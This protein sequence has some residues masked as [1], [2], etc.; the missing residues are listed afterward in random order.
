MTAARIMF[1]AIG[2][3]AVSRM[4]SMNKKYDDIHVNSK[5]PDI[6]TYTQFKSY[7]VYVSGIIVGIQEI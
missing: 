2:V 1:F 7:I 6:S 4:M 5:L 3:A